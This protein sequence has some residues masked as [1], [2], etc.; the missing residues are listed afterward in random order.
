[1]NRVKGLGGASAIMTLMV[2][3]ACATAPMTEGGTLSSYENLARSDGVVTRS[4]LRVDRAKVLSA[5]TVRIVSTMFSDRAA[6]KLSQTQRMLVA[7]VVDRSLCIGLSDRFSVVDSGAP[8]DLT[9]HATVTHA[10]ATDKLAAAASKVVGFIPSA[11][12]ANGIPVP[13]IPIGLGSLSIEAEATDATGKQDAAMLWGRGANAL[14]SSPKVSEVGDAYDLASAFGADFSGLLV[15]GETPFG[16][17]GKLPSLKKLGTSLGGRPKFVACES[18]G[19]NPGLT[20]IVAGGIGLPPEWSD[21]GATSR[22]GAV[23]TT[24]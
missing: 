3:T 5:R 2:L 14:A 9:I 17:L 20:G 10:T 4:R 13:R 23:S 8:A 1:M 7:N 15:M 11:L 21:K 12:G 6:P 19:R 18:F 24:Q 16:K 22:T